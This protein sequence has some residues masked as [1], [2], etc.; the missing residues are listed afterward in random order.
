MEGGLR[1]R[2]DGRDLEAPTTCVITGLDYCPSPCVKDY[3]ARVQR[4]ARTS[5]LIVK[6]IE[7]FVDRSN[8]CE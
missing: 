6:I 8:H 5:K 3:G 4:R 7:P 1:V 2:I